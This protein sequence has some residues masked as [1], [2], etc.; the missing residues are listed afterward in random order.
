MEKELSAAAL[1]QDSLSLILC[2]LK[3]E[4]ED[5][6]I[7]VMFSAHSTARSRLTLKAITSQFLCDRFI[8]RE[9]M[10]EDK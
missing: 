4:L 2:L 10:D 3:A 6:N 8:I 1:K 7:K 9:R 5:G